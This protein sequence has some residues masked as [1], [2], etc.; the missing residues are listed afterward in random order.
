MHHRKQYLTHVIAA[1]R[2]ATRHTTHRVLLLLVITA[3]SLT[4]R[5]QSP[6]YPAP[7]NFDQGGATQLRTD[8]PPV[9]GNLPDGRSLLA[10]RGIETGTLEVSISEDGVN[11]SKPVDT[12]VRT[13]G[14]I[15]FSYSYNPESSALQTYLMVYTGGSF[16]YMT[17]Q[18]GVTFTPPQ[19]V[20]LSIDG[21]EPVGSVSPSLSINGGSLALSLAEKTPGQPPAIDVLLSDQADGS[22][23]TSLRWFSDVPAASGAT[24]NSYAPLNSV[25][26]VVGVVF[27]TRPDNDVFFAQYSEENPEWFSTDTSLRVAGTPKWLHTYYGFYY[28]GRSVRDDGQVHDDYCSHEDHRLIETYS[29]DGTNFAPI[30][31]YNLF[32]KQGITVGFTP[33]SRIIVAFQS[34][35]GDRIET[36]TAAETDNVSDR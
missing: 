11:W 15:A 18:D 10:Y 4:A 29:Y 12:G 13:N 33:A 1:L 17:T 8:R 20:K 32:P 30:H 6:S 25:E 21:R 35:E 22:S 24:V 5:A 36:H 27:T 34:R 31:T 3:V 7:L 19:S 2:H 23:F 16:Q 26:P 14:A 28:F 9:L